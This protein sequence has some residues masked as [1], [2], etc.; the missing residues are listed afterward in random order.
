[1]LTRGLAALGAGLLLSCAPIASAA[2]DSASFTT[3]GEHQFVVPPA[4]F[5]L[6]VALVGGNGGMGNPG[7]AGGAPSTVKAT[8]AVM[9][10]QVLFVE[11]AG[12]GKPATADG[13]GL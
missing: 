5:S 10:G 1:M 12:D 7:T 9:P 3:A 2:S 4:V 8:L 11:V 6:D 13:Q